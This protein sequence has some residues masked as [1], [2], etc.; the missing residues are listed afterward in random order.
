MDCAKVVTACLTGTHEYLRQNK[1]LIVGIQTLHFPKQNT[2][3]IQSLAVSNRITER[4]F[5]NFLCMLII[6]SQQCGDCDR[7]FFRHLQLYFRVKHTNPSDGKDS[8]TCT[9]HE[10]ITHLICVNNI[11]IDMFLH[12]LATRSYRTGKPVMVYIWILYVCNG[13]VL[14][15][16]TLRKKISS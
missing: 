2:W 6:G 1:L 14:S 5:W 16:R 8:T 12:I 10:C 11:V 3:T 13:R 15:L 4:T 7:C 9:L